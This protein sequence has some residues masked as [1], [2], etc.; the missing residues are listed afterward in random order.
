MAATDFYEILGVDRNATGEEIQRAY[1]KLARTYH[2]DVNKDPAA[3]KRFQEISEA[4]DVLSDPSTRRRYD[5]FGPDF[6]QVP[7]HVDPETWA[8]APAPAVRG[9]R[10][11][12]TRASGSRRAFPMMT[13]ISR[14]CWAGCSDEA[15]AEGGGRSLAPTRRRSWC[16]R[17]RTPTGASGAPS[18]FRGP[19]SPGPWR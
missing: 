7:D 3:E 10:P 14:I 11:P 2:P 6:R 13:S 16:C 17:S 12:G 18:P 4:Y 8:R 15:G 9:R 5:A 1:R 19:A